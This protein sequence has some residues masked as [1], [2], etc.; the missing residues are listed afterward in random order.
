MQCARPQ[1]SFKYGFPK[2][3]IFVF[4][5]AFQN[6]TPKI[7]LLK[8]VK[9]IVVEFQDFESFPR[10]NYVNSAKTKKMKALLTMSWAARPAQ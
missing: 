1:K 5:K 6:N 7:N 8:T 4:L 3:N 10:A 2:N 9:M